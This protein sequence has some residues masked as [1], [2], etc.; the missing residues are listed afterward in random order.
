MQIEAIRST[1]ANTDFPYVLFADRTDSLQLETNRNPVRFCL[2]LSVIFTR[3]AR[4]KFSLLSAETSSKNETGAIFYTGS[5]QKNIEQ[6]R[7]NHP[8]RLIEVSWIS[9]H[10]TRCMSW[11]K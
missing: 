9:C 8:T 3:T 7:T 4:D 6:S 2:F 5:K 1:V 11:W 10:E